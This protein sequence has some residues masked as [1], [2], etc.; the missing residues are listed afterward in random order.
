MSGTFWRKPITAVSLA[1]LSFSTSARST[2][3]TESTEYHHMAYLVYLR[4]IMKRPQVNILRKQ[5]STSIPDTCPTSNLC[6]SRRLE[7]D[8]NGSCKVEFRRVG[9]QCDV[10]VRYVVRGEK[11]IARP[12]GSLHCQEQTLLCMLLA[13]TM[14]AW[15]KRHTYSS[16]PIAQ[17]ASDPQF[18][19]VPIP[20]SNT[21]YSVVW[22]I[23]CIE[24]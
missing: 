8:K 16:R 10:V 17:L 23:H 2:Q 18:A 14:C 24:S 15:E 11:T 1:K 9:L 4:A 22:T 21:V 19:L 5:A 13:R 12:C 3:K 20:K 6:R 7:C